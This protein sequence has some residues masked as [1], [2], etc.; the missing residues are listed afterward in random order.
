MKRIKSVLIEC[1]LA[2]MVFNS[3][4]TRVS[5]AF[6]GCKRSLVAT[7]TNSGTRT[8]HRAASEAKTTSNHHNDLVDDQP[9]PNAYKKA[10]LAKRQLDDTAIITI[11]ADNH[12]EEH[13][14][15][16]V[17]PSCKRSRGGRKKKTNR[18]RQ[19]VNPLSKKFQEPAQLG[20]SNFL[21]DVFTDPNKPLRI[22][23]GCGKGGFILQVA[24]E[25]TVK[26]KNYL[27]VEIRPPV[28]E[29]ALNRLERDHENIKGSLYYVSCNANVDLERILG[30]YTGSLTKEGNVIP[31]N[32]RKGGGKL[33]L[34][35]I[36]FP[37]PHF[38]KQQQKRRVVN[39]IFVD[40]LAKYMLPGSTIFLQSDVK[41]VLDDM[42][43]RFRESPYFKDDLESDDD[44]I[45]ENPLGI[46]TEREI[47]VL[48]RNLD[49]WRSLLIRTELKHSSKEQKQV[50]VQS[51]NE[52]N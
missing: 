19:H 51:S 33:D 30:Q 42:R 35:S 41:G 45:E 16:N 34:V 10:G 20:L 52:E 48:A 9:E 24:E 15:E 13:K 46:K 50:T 49:V 38:K 39:P 6:A 43:L 12:V 4:S 2:T 11:T 27:G 3:L 8:Q 28:V 37:D 18:F 32:E 23:I 17:E 1:L 31:E 25:D 40:T 14:N 21:P 22:D 26:D 7:F 5:A 29:F 44:Y 47:S 36:Q